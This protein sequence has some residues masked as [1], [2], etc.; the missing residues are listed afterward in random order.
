MRYYG[1]QYSLSM[2]L[3]SLLVKKELLKTSDV[4]AIQS[5]VR[6]E[7]ISIEEALTKHGITLEEALKRFSTACR[8]A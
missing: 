6:S 3:L 1:E 2:N 7:G 8:A 5:E 4:N